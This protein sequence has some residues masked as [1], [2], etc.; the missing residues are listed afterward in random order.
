MMYSGTPNSMGQSS[1]RT[2]VELCEARGLQMFPHS[3]NSLLVVQQMAPPA[4]QVPTL[5][6]T[7]L[8]IPQLAALAIP[9]FSAVSEPDN[10]AQPEEP[11]SPWHNPRDAPPPP[12]INYIPPTPL[13]ELDRPL[14]KPSDTNAK[15]AT[16]PTR[17][18]SLKQRVRRYSESLIQPLQLSRNN[19]LKRSPS[20]RAS[21][22]E[23]RPTYL[24]SMWTPRGFWEEYDSCDDSDDEFDPEDEHEPLPPGGD[25]SD[26]EEIPKRSVLPRNLSVRMPGFRG[27]GGFLIG[28]SLGIS[29]HGTNVRRHHVARRTS[30]EAIKRS[31]RYKGFKLSIPPTAQLRKSGQNAWKGLTT[32]RATREQEKRR[33]DLRAKIGPTIYNDK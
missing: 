26:V 4:R 20:K 33:D 19:T 18:L 14:G 24:S 29:R 13:S 2:E 27:T 7:S 31:P 5:E 9:Q 12:I 25:T 10:G 21:V 30:Q 3:N 15:S 1:I 32:S 23:E 28:N 8:E 6:Q 16:A 22:H 11:F 17:K